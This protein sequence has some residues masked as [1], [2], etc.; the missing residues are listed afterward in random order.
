M[1]SL[2]PTI[3][4]KGSM[5]LDDRVGSEG[6]KG[7]TRISASRCIGGRGKSMSASVMKRC[8]RC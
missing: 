2:F 3:T 6:D 1:T 5:G 7:C 4:R 8:I